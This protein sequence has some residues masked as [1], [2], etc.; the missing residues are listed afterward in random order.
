ME[1]IKK[2]KAVP[3]RPHGNLNAF[4]TMLKPVQ[5][6]LQHPKTTIVEVATNDEEE[7]QP[8]S[9]QAADISGKVM[10]TKDD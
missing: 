7:K 10:K 5:S 6:M 1:P 8:A 9:A 2:K 4:G 3:A